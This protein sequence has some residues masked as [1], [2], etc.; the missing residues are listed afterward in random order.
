MSPKSTQKYIKGSC[1]VKKKPRLCNLF[2]FEF[3]KHFEIKIVNASYNGLEGT[4]FGS[5]M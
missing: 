1:F 2:L 5:K 4:L 3:M